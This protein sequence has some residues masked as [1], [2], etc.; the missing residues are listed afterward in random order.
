MGRH[1]SGEQGKG[2]ES[3]AHSISATRAESGM[4]YDTVFLPEPMAESSGFVWGRWV[5]AENVL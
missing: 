4:Q 2:S 5:V 1:R 3:N